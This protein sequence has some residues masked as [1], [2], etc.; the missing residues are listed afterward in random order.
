MMGMAHDRPSDPV[1]IVA[2]HTIFTVLVKLS[3]KDTP[4]SS[5][6]FKCVATRL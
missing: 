6:N 5:A 2:D 1:D 3:F 4:H